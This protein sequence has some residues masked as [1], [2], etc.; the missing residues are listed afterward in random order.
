MNCDL[1][2]LKVASLVLLCILAWNPS[3]GFSNTD[4]LSILNDP[5]FVDFFQLFGKR[6]NCNAFRGVSNNIGFLFIK[7]ISSHEKVF[8]CPLFE[9]SKIKGGFVNIQSQERCL[10]IILLILVRKQQKRAFPK[11]SFSYTFFTYLNSFLGPLII[12]WNFEMLIKSC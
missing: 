5:F 2:F 6:K 4:L 9:L 11:N 10:L 3:P 12:L 8:D 1:F 7:D